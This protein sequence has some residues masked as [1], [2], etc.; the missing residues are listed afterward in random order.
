MLVRPTAAVP[1]RAA[2]ARACASWRA[3]AGAAASAVILSACSSASHVEPDI[4]RPSSGVSVEARE[5]AAAGWQEAR[6]VTPSR[7]L[8]CVPYARRISGIAIRGDAWTWWQAADGRYA[9]SARP[10]PGAVLVLKRT[11]R[12]RGGHLA[13]VTGLLSEREIVVEHA[14]WLNRG[15]I[16]KGS[17]VM[18]VSKNNDWSVVRIWYTPGRQY[19]VRSYPA[20][21][22]ILPASRISATPVRRPRS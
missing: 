4:G 11:S 10:E 22:F 16:H 9:R 17:L 20:Y 3:L 1:A 6:I 15:R 13:V 21:G 12:L 2:R 7:P 14:N 18:D 8:E 5:P 19:G